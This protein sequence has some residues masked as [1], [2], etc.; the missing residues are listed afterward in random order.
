VPI[1]VDAVR[2]TYV[3][4]Q[5]ATLLTGGCRPPHMPKGYY[6]LPVRTALVPTLQ[7][8][9]RD[10]GVISEDHLRIP[11]GSDRRPAPVWG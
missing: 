4:T 6:L 8:F 10:N 2:A 5:G 9:L 7:K 11:T 3:F 1:H